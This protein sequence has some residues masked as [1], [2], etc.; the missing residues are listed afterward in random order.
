MQLAPEIQITLIRGLLTDISFRAR[1]IELIRRFAMAYSQ[2]TTIRL[3]TYN[4]FKILFSIPERCYPISDEL[5]DFLTGT[6]PPTIDV[7][8]TLLNKY[9]LLSGDPSFLTVFLVD[10][11][12]AQRLSVPRQ[13]E[14][15]IL[16]MTHDEH[17]HGGI[18]RTYQNIRARFFFL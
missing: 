8:Q 12:G 11:Y 9:Q 3:I 10:N 7:L 14:P 4:N 18:E 16:S 17:S 2:D 13:M 15:L 1:T 5:R 6:L